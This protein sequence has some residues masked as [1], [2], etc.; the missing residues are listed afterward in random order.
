M[1]YQRQSNTDASHDTLSQILF[2]VVL[3]DGKV[4]T[5]DGVKACHI[6]AAQ[7]NGN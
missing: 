2:L 3:V 5:D 1:T 7:T 6:D 4:L